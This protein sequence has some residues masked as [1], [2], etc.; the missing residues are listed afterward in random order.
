MRRPLDV[1]LEEAVKVTKR[2]LLTSTRCDSGGD[3]RKLVADAA[4]LFS[5]VE[6]TMRNERLDQEKKSAVDGPGYQ[7]PTYR[8]RLVE[9]RLAEP[10]TAERQQAQVQKRQPRQEHKPTRRGTEER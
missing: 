3:M 4:E 2:R 9:P 1:S 6:V 5:E 7:S 10:R 8:E